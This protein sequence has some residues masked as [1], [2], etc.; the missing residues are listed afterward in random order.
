MRI[1]GFG[2]KYM[3]AELAEVAVDTIEEDK[4]EDSLIFT[5]FCW[6]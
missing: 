4:F 1:L 6:N 3:P 5:G 2:Y